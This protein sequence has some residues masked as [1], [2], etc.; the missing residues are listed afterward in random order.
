MAS[1]QS[2]L[3][4]VTVWFG[5]SQVGDVATQ[6]SKFELNLKEPE[7]TLV[8][9][10]QVLETAQSAAAAAASSGFTGFSGQA[11]PPRDRNVFDPRDFKLAELGVKPE[12]A[13]WK[14]WRRDFENYVDTI[15]PS[16]RGTSGL[17]R[18]IR[19]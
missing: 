5:A 14:K 17:L 4:A 13:R 15:D 6:V 18:E 3:D 7:S 12:V 10:I 1:I 2:Q 19:H 16:W 9:K 8:R 11:P